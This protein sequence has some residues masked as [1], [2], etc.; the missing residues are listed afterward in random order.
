MADYYQIL[1]VPRDA[2]DKDIRQAFRRMARKFHP[3]LNRGDKEAEERFKE[4]NEAHEVLSDSEKRRKYDR[5][6]D[7]WK[8]ADQIDAQF[9]RGTGSPFDFSHG[10]GG[11]PEDFGFD[12]F[13]GLDDLLGGLGGRRPRRGAT[14]T[15]RRIDG[16]LE[17]TLEQAFAGTKSHVSFPSGSGERRIEVTIPPGVD[18]GSVVHVS[19]DK[20]SDLYLTIAVA[21]HKR[22][23]R[24]GN[25]LYTE[26]DIP[27]EEALLGGEA[28]VTTLKGRVHLKVPPESQNGQRIRLAGQGMPKLGA[29]DTKGDLYVTVRPAMP[30][31]LTEGQREL[32]ERFK[33]LRVGKGQGTTE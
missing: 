16:T 14:A 28:E 4:I 13:G 5:Y 17:V 26:V 11:V 8:Q 10:R 18:D 33:E 1:G 2:T 6:G 20:D 25:D 27:F 29:Q 24:E 31:N 21:T 3:D 30:K 15:K 19:P 23:R 7:R 9:G 22:F 32:I 12:L